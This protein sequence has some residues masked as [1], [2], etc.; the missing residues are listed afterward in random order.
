MDDEALL[1]RPRRD[2]R[3]MILI[4][5]EATRRYISQSSD[6]SALL[7]AVKEA[8]NRARGTERYLFASRDALVSSR[9]RA[10]LVA[11]DAPVEGPAEGGSWRLYEM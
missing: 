2:G 10:V 1:L 3:A 11:D 7:A 4:L 6:D 9:E 8:I 5:N